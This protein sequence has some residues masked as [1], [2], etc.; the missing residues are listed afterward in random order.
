MP[1]AL[2]FSQREQIVQRHQQGET[3]VAIAQSLKV[4]YRT[5]RQWW[6]RFREEG[7]AGLKTRYDH[8]GPARPRT[9]PAVHHAAL[10]MKREHPTWGAGLIRLEL[11]KQF[12]D[13]RLPKER[14]IQRWFRAAGLQP[15]RAQG[16]PVARQRAQEPHAVW[17][18]DAKEQM[19]LADG[20]PTSVLT[21]TDEASGAL[22]GVTPFPPVSLE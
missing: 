18:I 11:Q 17:E 19:S 10:A 1:H 22:L 2:P 8:C 14:A 5:A 15:R 4:K 16:P 9:A 3:L 12:P 20:S 21:V 7:E 6:R 13:E